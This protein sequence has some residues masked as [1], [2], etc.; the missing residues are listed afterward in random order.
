MFL[1]LSFHTPMENI[2]SNVLSICHCV[3]GQVDGADQKARAG[4]IHHF[5]LTQSYRH[6]SGKKTKADRS[7]FS[8]QPSVRGD[9][10]VA[11]CACGS[12]HRAFSIGPFHRCHSYHCVRVTNSGGSHYTMIW[13]PSAHKGTHTLRLFT[14]ECIQ[15]CTHSSSRPHTTL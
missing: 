9:R 7:S 13:V 12:V 11:E 14:Y 5:Q 4:L 8:L 10:C 2:T 6:P 3:R 15:F 1:L